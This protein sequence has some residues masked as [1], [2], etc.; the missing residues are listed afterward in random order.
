MISM[1]DPRSGTLKA[2][3]ERER[4]KK[5]AVKIYRELKRYN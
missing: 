2:W 5:Q 3:K 4:E 1:K